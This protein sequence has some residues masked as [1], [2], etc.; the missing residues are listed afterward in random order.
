MSPSPPPPCG[1]TR[2]RMQR[3]VMAMTVAVACML[4]SCAAPTVQVATIS[5]TPPL[6]RNNCYSLLHQLLDQQKKIA[7]LR[8]VKREEEDIKGLI[9]RI[10]AHSRDHAKLLEK[11]AKDDPSLNL[12]DLR[13]PPGEEAT[14]AAIAASRKQELLNQTGAEFE[15]TLLLSQAQALSYAWHLAKV[16]SENEAHPDRAHALVRVSDDMKN[17]YHEVFALLLARAK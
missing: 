9:M 1:S 12:N 15:M 4:T 10:A 5:T 14:R 16:A 6:T 7:L 2:I 17:L 11:F 13:I 3:C 8:F